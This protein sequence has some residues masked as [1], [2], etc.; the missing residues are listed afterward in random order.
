MNRIWWVCNSLC[1][2]YV[3]SLLFFLSSLILSLLSFAFAVRTHRTF[4][5][6]ILLTFSNHL[7]A[8][9]KVNICVVCFAYGYRICLACNVLRWFGHP[10]FFTCLLL[11]ASFK[12][13]VMHL[14]LLLSSFHSIAIL[15]QHFLWFWVAAWFVCIFKVRCT[16][17]HRFAYHLLKM[18]SIFSKKTTKCSWLNDIHTFLLLCPKISSPHVVW[19]Q[20]MP[21]IPPRK[22]KENY[23]TFKGCPL[24]TS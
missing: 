21:L 14:F 18:Q 1:P 8:G 12:L 2:F 11:D 20:K 24:A 23:A 10:T 15:L 9:C 6:L 7:F 16:S 3:N 17:S 19:V 22:Q 13:W 4:L 5:S